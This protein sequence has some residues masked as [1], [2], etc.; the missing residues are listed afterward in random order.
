M[1]ILD[2]VFNFGGWHVE[3]LSE[4]VE[5][6]SKMGMVCTTSIVMRLANSNSFLWSVNYVVW[7]GQILDSGIVEG[8]K[9]ANGVSNGNNQFRFWKVVVNILQ[10][11]G[12]I[13]IV[14]A[15]V[16]SLI[17]LVGVHIIHV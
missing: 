7:I 1:R 13:D 12:L 6:Q 5:P 16:S 10:G 17:I 2:D 4:F 11:T 3:C 15:V 8:F 14:D 9:K